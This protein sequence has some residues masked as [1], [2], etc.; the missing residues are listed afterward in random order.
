MLSTKN[1]HLIEL[2]T[3][4]TH[5]SYHIG[6]ERSHNEDWKGEVALNILLKKKNQRYFDFKICEIG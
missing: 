4:T 1:Q 3:N 6:S 2:Y 5:Q